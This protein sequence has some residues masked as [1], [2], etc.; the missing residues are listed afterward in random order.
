ME[1][2]SAF[3]YV[4]DKLMKDVDYEKWTNYIEDI[5]K[6]YGVIP[7]N[8]AELACGTGNLTNKLVGR[9]YNLIGVDCSEDMLSVAQEKAMDVSEGSVIYLN[10]DMRELFLPTEL[11]A[12]LCVCDGMNYITKD[13][14]ITKI[15]KSVYEHLKSG[16]LFI[17]DVSSYYKL[18]TILGQNTY[19]E[20][21]EGVSYIWE[22]YFDET[23][24]I[25]DFDLTIFVKE[26]KI[27]KKYEENHKQRA[28][29][30][31]EIIEN[32]KN[33][34]FEKINVFD[35]F[36]FEEPKENSERIYFVCKKM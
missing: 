2:Y 1:A 22:N 5:F 14:E 36:G 33:A 25:C 16:G 19:A 8:M 3:A 15:F 28:H 34:G 13:E 11:D 7:K 9:G 21:Y 26:G 27:Y 6:R 10:Q 32:L 18:S 17:F 20:N 4:Y 30:E 31:N 23:K 24:N 35:A 12:I 29:K